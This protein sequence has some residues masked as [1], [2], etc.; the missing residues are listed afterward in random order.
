MGDGKEL[1]RSPILHVGNREDVQV[2]VSEVKILELLTTGGEGH[3]HN[4]W[5]IWADPKVSR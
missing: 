4:S 5:A 1:Y 2:D 3:N